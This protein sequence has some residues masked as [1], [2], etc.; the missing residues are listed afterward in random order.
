MSICSF[1]KRLL[2]AKLHFGRNLCLKLC[3]S[4]ALYWFF[5]RFFIIFLYL[6]VCVIFNNVINEPRLSW[7]SLPRLIRKKWFFKQTGG[8]CL[9]LKIAISKEIIKKG[10]P[11]NS[12]YLL[13]TDGRH[14]IK[15][16]WLF[17]ISKKKIGNSFSY[18]IFIFFLF[19]SLQF[20]IPIPV[21]CM[22]KKKKKKPKDSVVTF[23]FWRRYL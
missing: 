20:K 14:L 11:A 6:N 12:R 19:P 21:A 22:N 9:R 1:L 4:K 15:K 16:M 18:F 5:V 2:L 10:T 8:K 13:G 7:R 23:V 3:T 17:T